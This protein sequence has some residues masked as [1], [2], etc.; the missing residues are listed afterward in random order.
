MLSDVMGLKDMILGSIA[1]NIIKRNRLE[2]V[3]ILNP[4]QEVS[5][6]K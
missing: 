1:V 3:G 6:E 2:K 4:V 5:L